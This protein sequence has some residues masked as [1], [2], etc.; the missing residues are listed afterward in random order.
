MLAAIVDHR[1]AYAV[2]VSGWDRNEDFFVEKTELH[3]TEAYGKHIELLRPIASGAILFLRL[4]DPMSAD[5]VSPVPYLADGM[6][7]TEAGRHK[8]RLAVAPP[9][10][11][12]G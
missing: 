9:R 3:W 5:R 4:L 8:V 2:E 11:R 10:M 7:A 6:E 12:I 1:T